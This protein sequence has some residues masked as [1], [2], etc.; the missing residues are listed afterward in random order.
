MLKENIK[1][2]FSFFLKS[3]L[4]YAHFGV[5]HRCNL[6]CQMCNYYQNTEEELTFEQIKEL[7]N[8]LSEL[9]IRYISLGGGE[10]LLR[11]DIIPIVKT[12]KEKKIQ[13]RLLTNSLLLEEELIKELSKMKISFSVSLDSLNKKIQEDIWQ[14][15]PGTHQQVITN[16]EKIAKNRHQEL[17]IINTVIFRQNLKELKNLINFA[18]RLNYYISFIPLETSKKLSSRSSISE[19]SQLIEQAIEEIIALKREGKKI[20]N[21]TLFLQQLK[22]YLKEE[23]SFTNCHAGKYYISISP[24]GK[25]SIC[26]NFLDKLTYSYKEIPSY[27]F[28][29]NY[30]EKRRQLINNC[31]GC[32]RPCWQEI[33]NLF[34]SPKSFWEIL[35]NINNA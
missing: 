32:M 25:I 12:F 22:K 1:S 35:K 14:A 5:T 20:F 33:S 3:Q 10:P 21:T 6:A 16:L 24:Q 15:K 17:H 13:V 34:R 7:A 4:F 8:I 31:S 2:F 9:G 26:H 18:D 30:R 23:K 27:F 29:N 19:E 28:T 11:K